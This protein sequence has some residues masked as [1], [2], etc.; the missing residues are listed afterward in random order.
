MEL[1]IK[2][3]QRLLRPQRNNKVNGRTANITHHRQVHISCLLAA[4]ARWERWLTVP[5]LQRHKSHPVLMNSVPRRSSKGYGTPAR[6]EGLYEK[7]AHSYRGVSL[8]LFPHSLQ[9][10]HSFSVSHSHIKMQILKLETHREKHIFLPR[11]LLN[12]ARSHIAA[13]DCHAKPEKNPSPNR[14]CSVFSPLLW[15]FQ[16]SEDG[17]AAK[18]SIIESLIIHCFLLFGMTF[19]PFQQIKSKWEK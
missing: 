9:V 17:S 6:R 4:E 14:L 10:F 12:K 18:S 3:L 1:I 7:V 5:T 19:F 16:P 13:S 11:L 2:H 15:A 8:L